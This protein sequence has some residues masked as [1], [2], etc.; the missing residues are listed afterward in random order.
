SFQS[1][2]IGEIPLAELCGFILTHKECLADTDPTTSIA[3]E[4]GVNRLTTNT[5]KRLEEAI[6]KAEQILS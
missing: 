6:C 5:R 1:R 4:L 3:R 2:S